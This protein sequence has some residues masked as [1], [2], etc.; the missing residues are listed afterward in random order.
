MTHRPQV[1]L[2][3][4]NLWAVVWSS[5]VLIWSLLGGSELTCAF[6]LVIIIFNITLLRMV[7]QI[8]CVVLWLIAHICWQGLSKTWLSAGAL[9]VGIIG[10]LRSFSLSNA[11]FSGS[12]RLR[13]CRR[14]LLWWSS[15]FGCRLAFGVVGLGAL[16]WRLKSWLVALDCWAFSSLAMHT[17]ASVA[18]WWSLFSFLMWIVSSTW[19]LRTRGKMPPDI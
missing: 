2:I 16:D 7:S 10:V 13:L 1:L 15:L 3:V 19:T 12:S 9:I 11:F 8:G 18:T 6:T 14:C 17:C 5:V 4:R